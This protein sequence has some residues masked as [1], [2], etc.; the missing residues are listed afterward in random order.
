[1]NA[2]RTGGSKTFTSKAGHFERTEAVH[3]HCDI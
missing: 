1:M 3:L 2:Y